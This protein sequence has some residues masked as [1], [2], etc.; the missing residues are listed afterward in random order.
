MEHLERDSPAWPDYREWRLW[1]KGRVRWGLMYL[2]GVGVTENSHQ[3]L[4]WIA[5]AAQQ[6]FGDAV[7]VFDYMLTH[8][9]VLSC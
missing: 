2:E 7:D 6:G 9:A 5:K 4:D 8:D 3:A 1:R